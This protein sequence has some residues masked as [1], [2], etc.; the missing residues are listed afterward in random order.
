MRSIDHKNVLITGVSS[1]IGFA[2]TER[3]LDA[4]YSVVGI[5]RTKPLL[6]ESDNFTWIQYDLANDFSEEIASRITEKNITDI[7]LCA[8]VSGMESIDESKNLSISVVRKVNYESQRA[9][10]EKVIETQTD[11]N[12]YYFSSSLLLKEV[13]VSGSE[14]YIEIK[15][16]MI[17]FL[18]TLSTNVQIINPGLVNTPL[19][20]SLK[21][22]KSLELQE[23]YQNA[24]DNG[25]VK[26]VKDF[27]EEFYN[28][29]FK[30]P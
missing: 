6:I 24:V 21:N 26:S 18:S 17:Q 11:P 14:L 15:K 19:F 13:P 27:A 8:T 22:M 20:K 23:R 29:Y 25:I 28:N 12:I 1:G 10:I 9:L 4:G 30:K 2:I 5:S 3:L 7:I 16:E